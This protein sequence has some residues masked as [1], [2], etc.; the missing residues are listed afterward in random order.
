MSDQGGRAVYRRG[1]HRGFSPD[2]LTYGEQL[3][4]HAL[5]AVAGEFLSKLP[6]VQGPYDEGDPWEKWLN[7]RV[8]TRKDGLWLADA[9]DRRPLATRINLRKVNEST[10]GL[11]GAPSTLLSLLGISGELGDW[12]VVDG[13]WKSIDGI[14]VHIRSALVSAKAEGKH[15]GRI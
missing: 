12:L 13:E 5:H 2:H 10:V 14:D 8:W 9:T 1:G 4:W 6:V 11:T 3:C 7:R 15:S